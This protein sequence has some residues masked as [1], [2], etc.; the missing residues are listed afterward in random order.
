MDRA[1]MLL[2]AV[3]SATLTS[4]CASSNDKTDNT[5][6][7]SGKPKDTGVKDTSTPVE[8]DGPTVDTGTVVTDSTTPS[9]TTSGGDTATTV[10]DPHTGDECNMVK[11]DCPMAAQTCAYDGT[12]KH[13]ACTTLPTGTKLKGEACATQADCD[14][15]LFCYSNKC[16]PACCTGDNSVCGAG[17]TCNLA[18]T[19][20]SGAVIY[21]A[22]SYSSKCNAFKY[23]CPKGQVC[24]FNEDHD[25]FKCSTPSSGAT[26]VGAAPGITCKY[27]NDCG[28]SQACFALSSGGDA[29]GAPYKCY[30]FCWLTTPGGFTPG[31]TPD[32]RFPANGT[33]TV[34]G[35]N[36][37]TCTS[38]GGI[39]G[40]L[41]ICV[42]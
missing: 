3:L 1:R 34:G 23:D 28:E 15:G 18:I 7:D 24:L 8:D 33:C 29:A 10:C 41:G 42:K 38:L 4:A 35:T 2:A 6:I 40:G 21:H 36:Y 5:V 26:G 32:G 19:E 25:V 27:S 17:G 11:Q 39:G 20:D 9:D 30:L 14:R 31:S 22:C 12:K 16:S 13:N 37:G